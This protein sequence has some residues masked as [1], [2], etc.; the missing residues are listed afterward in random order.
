MYPPE[1][2][3]SINNRPHERRDNFNRECSFVA[4]R[5]GF[6]IHSGV[7]RSTAY[8]HPEVDA[9]TYFAAQYWLVAGPAERDAFITQIVGGA[10]LEGAEHRAFIAGR[11]DWTLKAPKAR[12]SQGNAHFTATRDGTLQERVSAYTLRHLHARTTGK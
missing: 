1:T 4:S 11:P 10:A 9:N 12:G 7:H 5:G 8:I 2:I 6:V 3:K